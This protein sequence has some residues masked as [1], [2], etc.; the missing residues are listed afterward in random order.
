MLRAVK[1]GHSF[2][3]TN[4][5][6]PVG[7]IIP[8]DSPTPALAIAREAKRVGGWADLRIQRKAG[9]R[10]LHETVDDLREDRV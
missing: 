3:L 5:G 1:E 10:P 2:V 4:A 7:R 9:S 6:V 8:I